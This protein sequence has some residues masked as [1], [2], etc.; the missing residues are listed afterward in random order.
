MSCFKFVATTVYHGMFCDDGQSAEI[1]HHVHAPNP[2]TD[3]FLMTII[4]DTQKNR[5]K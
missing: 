3:I 1:C 2:R 4:F 5:I